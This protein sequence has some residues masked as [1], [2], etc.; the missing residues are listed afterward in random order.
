MT[1]EAAG[2]PG[3]CPRVLRW[4]AAVQLSD[5]ATRAP[6]RVLGERGALK[7]F[8]VQELPLLGARRSWLI[9]APGNDPLAGAMY[10]EGASERRVTVLLS[11]LPPAPASSGELRSLWLYETVQQPGRWRI[12]GFRACDVGPPGSGRQNA[13]CVARDGLSAAHVHALLAKL[14]AERGGR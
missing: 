3:L 13:R 12:A 5:P 7:R 10:T 8:S 11:R 9:L 6:G 4:A 1:R 2:P 14:N